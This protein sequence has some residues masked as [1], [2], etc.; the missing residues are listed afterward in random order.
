MSRLITLPVPAEEITSLQCGEQ[1]LLSGVMVTM[2]DRAHRWL[3]DNPEPDSITNELA[4]W[5]DGGA[6]YHCGP[7]VTG[8]SLA[9]YRVTAAGPTTSIRQ[10]SYTPG[11][12]RRFNARVVIGKGGMGAAT[13][14]ACEQIPAVYLH[15][16][17]GAASLLAQQVERVEAVYR[18]DFGMAEAIWVLR[19]TEFPA[20]VTMDAHG[21]S[22]HAQVAASSSS[23]FKELLQLK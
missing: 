18:L 1:V 17:G 16:T 8:N 13:L 14:A 3:M 6:I 21:S 9:D 22:L 5:L 15:A 11:V 7:V 2:R 10:E 23:I 12:L 19:V 4:G 20:I